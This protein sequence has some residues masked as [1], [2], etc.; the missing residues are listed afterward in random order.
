[1]GEYKIN[2]R[3]L[4]EIRKYLNH[5]LKHLGHHCCAI[6]IKEHNRII[7]ITYELERLK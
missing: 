6:D 1:M 3:E 5:L 2:S 4:K 7:N